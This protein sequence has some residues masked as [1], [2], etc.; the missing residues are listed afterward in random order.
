MLEKLHNLENGNV[1]KLFGTFV[2]D[3]WGYLTWE[4]FLQM[5]SLFNAD[6]KDYEVDMLFKHFDPEGTKQIT[7]LQFEKGFRAAGIK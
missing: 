4:D 7:L 1:E 2:M 3:K 6:L 5:I